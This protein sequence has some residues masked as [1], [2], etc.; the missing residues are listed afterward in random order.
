VE[1]EYS[2]NKLAV[3]G[4]SITESIRLLGVSAG[5]KYIQRLTILRATDKFHQLY[6]HQALHLH[7]LKGDRVGQYAITLTG[8]YRLIIK[9][10]QEDRVLVLGVEDYHGD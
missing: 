2:N 5:R 9:V 7:Q 3:A 6:G 4:V 1:I 10:I 8:N